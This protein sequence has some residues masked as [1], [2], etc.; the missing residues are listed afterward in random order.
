[1]VGKAKSQGPHRRQWDVEDVTVTDLSSM[2]R[3][4]TATAVGNFMEWYDFGLYAY[5]ATVISQVF[6]P[7]DSSTTAGMLGTFVILAASFIARPFGGLVFG[8][9]GDRIGRRK[10]LAVTILTMAVATTITGLLPGYA[11]GGIWGDGIGVWAVVALLVTRLVQGFST[12]GEYVGAMIYLAEHAPDRRRGMLGGFLPL[13]T[14]LGFVVGAA[15]V[16]GLTAGLSES[17][18]LSWGWRIP[19]LLSGPL[20]IIALYMRLR[21]EETPAFE[22][23]NE[24]QQDDKQSRSQQFRETIIQQWPQLLVCVGLVLT[25]NLTNYMLTGYLPSYLQNIVKM[26][27]TSALAIVTAVLVV[28]AIA[29]VFVAR[30]SDIMSRKLIMSVGC[31]LLIVGAI[32]AFLLIHS[33]ESYLIVFL[34]VLMVG[35][36]LLGFNSTEPSTVPTLFPTKVRYGSTAIAFNVSVAV[37]GGTTPLIAEGLISATGDEMVPAYML[38]FGGVVGIVSVYFTPEPSRRRLRGSGP[39]V[40]SD[41]EANYVSR[42]G[43]IEDP[44]KSETG[45]TETEPGQE[46]RARKTGV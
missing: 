25:F 39:I 2:R 35:L 36:M 9:L 33:G 10:V 5:L 30:L 38:M 44:T 41:E 27:S 11:D 12:G 26:S 6:F 45:L 22:K 42:T 17:A 37:F 40:S 14:L 29:V 8:P 23:M 13:G 46:D 43:T 21:M 34:G 7:S 24:E 1:M 28:L 20:G 15:L 3:S 19:F 18:M 16:T 31:G 32:P 4:V